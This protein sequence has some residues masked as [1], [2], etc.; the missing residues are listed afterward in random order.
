MSFFDI[1]HDRQEVTYQ[2]YAFVLHYPNDACHV[3]EDLAVSTVVSVSLQS[4]LEVMFFFLSG[5][6]LAAALVERAI[7]IPTIRTKPE[8]QR[9]SVGFAPHH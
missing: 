2:I 4:L 6:L 8:M 5:K 9:I 1:A 3:R 7:L